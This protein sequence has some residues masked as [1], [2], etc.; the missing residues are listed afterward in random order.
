MTPPEDGSHEARRRVDAV[1]LVAL[2]GGVI[3][4]VVALQRADADTPAW[5]RYA[6]RIA[7]VVL[8]LRIWFR[9]QE[10]IASR[11]MP[12]GVI[13]DGIHA[14]TSPLHAWLES[15][16]RSAD[17]ILI[18]SSLFIDLF[19]LFVIGAG[20][21]G[22]TLRPFI[23]LLILFAMRQVCQ[24]V[25]ALPPPPGMIWRHPGFPSLLVTYGTAS[26]FFF[27]GHTAIA[28]LGTL[29]MS[30]IGP[31]WLTIAA[32]SIA[33]L[34]AAVV[35]VLRAHYTM[36]VVAAVLAAWFAYQVAGLVAPGL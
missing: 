26:D 36:D 14:L 24:A 32:G 29:V 2:A 17:R 27:S 6:L 20:I 7:V 11:V 28:V 8:S 34:E 16:P 10:R 35:L 23:A 3:C 15:R 9:T 19:G 13:A 4:C 22:P 12:P 18:A 25:C 33:I 5:V 1:L 30:G 31:L 21:L